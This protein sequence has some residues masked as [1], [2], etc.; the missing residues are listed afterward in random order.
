MT[1]CYFHNACNPEAA[2]HLLTSNKTTNSNKVIHWPLW[3]DGLA[4][5]FS[6]S[7]E[8][9]RTRVVE[10]PQTTKIHPDARVAT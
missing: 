7:K 10:P 3:K 1:G 2:K 6:A 4:W 9:I 8:G 5:T